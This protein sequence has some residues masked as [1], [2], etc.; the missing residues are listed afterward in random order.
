VRDLGVAILD[1]LKNA[2]ADGSAGEFVDGRSIRT[3]AIVIK[4]NLIGIALN[5]L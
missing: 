3:H 1:L 5:N 2:D 4:R